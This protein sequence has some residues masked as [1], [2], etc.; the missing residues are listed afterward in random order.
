MMST[1]E[2]IARLRDR[3]RC[4]EHRHPVAGGHVLRSG[5][6]P[7][8]RLLPDGGVRRGS[9]VEWLEGEAGSGAATLALHYARQACREGG[10]L[11]VAD[12]L[13]QVYPP[14]LA[15]WGIDLSQVILVH[16]RSSREEVWVWDQALRCPAVA[17]VWGEIDRIDGRS[18]RRL[19]LAVE[20]SGALADG[21]SLAAILVEIEDSLS[22]RALRRITW[23]LQATSAGVATGRM[24]EFLE[25]AGRECRER[26]WGVTPEMDLYRKE[27]RRT[28]AIIRELVQELP[29]MDRRVLE[30][31]FD[32]GWPARRIA[33]ELALTYPREVYTIIHRATQTLRRLLG[34]L[35]G[36]L[37]LKAIPIDAI[38]DL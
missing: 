27:T 20:E 38:P 9:L 29:E 8:D 24:L 33:E 12:R 13:R 35:G 36:I 32:D 15:A 16:P 22:S 11:V 6:E 7:L 3:I 23:D 28:V 14:A 17:A 18:F 1:P 4:L 34:P 30:L 5:C 26:S 10:V 21:D 2:T 25:A 31:R 37:A 19:Q